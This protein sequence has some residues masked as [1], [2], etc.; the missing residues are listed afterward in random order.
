MSTEYVDETRR[1]A[2]VEVHSIWL[3]R[4]SVRPIWLAAAILGTLAGLFAFWPLM[5][6]SGVAAVLI[7]LGW[8]SEARS[9]SDELPLN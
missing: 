3:P 1:P 6:V 8:I 7:A 2:P 5:L 4:T 9:E